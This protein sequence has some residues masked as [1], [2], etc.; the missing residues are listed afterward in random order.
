[1]N[2]T[3][4]AN[5]ELGIRNPNS[6]FIIRNS[7]IFLLFT[8]VIFF[9]AGCNRVSALRNDGTVHLA[10][11]KIIVQTARTEQEQQIGLSSFASIDENHGMLFPIIPARRLVFWMKDM[12]FSIDI[13]WI[14]NGQVI[15]L[16]L[17]AVPEPGKADDQLKLY[18]PGSDVDAVLELQAGWAEKHGIKIGDNITF[19][20]L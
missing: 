20:L 2:K 11:K 6:K 19:E 17:N 9:G 15:D 18:M 13:V 1:M 3:G 16:S 7:K 5:L 8:A 4:R 12:K 10:G 14:K